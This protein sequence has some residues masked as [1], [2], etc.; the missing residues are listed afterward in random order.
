MMWMGDAAVEGEDGV[1]VV[2][3]DSSV[4][5]LS[6]EVEAASSVED[7]AEEVWVLSSSGIGSG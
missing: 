6:G 1:V 5:G 3:E 4:V 2:V 7:G